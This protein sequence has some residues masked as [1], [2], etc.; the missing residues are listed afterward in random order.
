MI[1]FFRGFFHG[2]SLI[3]MLLYIWSKRNPNA[4]VSI[5]GIMQLQVRGSCQACWVMFAAVLCALPADRPAA[6]AAPALSAGGAWAVSVTPAAARGGQAKCSGSEKVHLCRAAGP[7]IHS[8]AKLVSP[9]LR[10]SRRPPAGPA[11]ALCLP[12]DRPHGAGGLEGGPTGHPVGPC[13][14]RCTASHDAF[15]SD[16]CSMC[17]AP[18]ALLVCGLAMRGGTAPSD[19][20]S[21]TSESVPHILC[22]CLPTPG[23]VSPLRYYFLRDVYP[24]SSG[25]NVIQTPAWL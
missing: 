5:F 3:F 1:P 13:V 20:Y 4:P 24:L 12:G 14:S 11:P 21:G 7:L 9:L 10:P 25:R 17:L 16:V 15:Y 8:P 22:P 18:L 2:S 23:A 19:C 6:P